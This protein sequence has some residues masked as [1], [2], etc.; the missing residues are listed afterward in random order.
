MHYANG[1]P[2]RNGDKVL[3]VVY[4][5]VVVGVLYDAKA[6]N[7]FCNGQLAPIGGGPHIGACLADCVHLDDVLFALNLD[8]ASGKV[9]EQLKA[10]PVLPVGG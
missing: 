5:T 4:Q 3:Q 2:A 8:L 9:R 1:R 10:V 6:G 7:D